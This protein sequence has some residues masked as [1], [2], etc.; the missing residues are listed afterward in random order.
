M[1]FEP[2]TAWTTTDPGQSGAT[3]IPFVC[4]RFEV[5]VERCFAQLMPRKL[6]QATTGALRAEPHATA[7]KSRSISPSTLR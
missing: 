2:T 1:G 4:A 6:A 5:V 7:A 3:P